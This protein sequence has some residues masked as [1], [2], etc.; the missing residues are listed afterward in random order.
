M[1]EREVLE[2]YFKQ[3]ILLALVCT[4]TL[5]SG[6]NFPARRVIVRTPM[7]IGGKTIDIMSYRQMIGRAGRKGIDTEGESILMCSNAAE[8]RLGECLINSELPELSSTMGIAAPFTTKGNKQQNVNELASSMKRAILE[9]IV[10]GIATTKEDLKLYS[11]CFLSKQE[12]EIKGLDIDIYLNWLYKNEFIDVVVDKTS[13]ET[14]PQKQS[15]KPTQLGFA[16][17]SSAMCPDEGIL[18]F[19]ELQKA[20]QCFVLENELHII[21][22]ITPINICD[23]WSSSSSID[24]NVYYSMIQNMSNDYKR[25]ADLVGVRQS[26]ILKMIKNGSNTMTTINDKKLSRIHLR[27]YTALILN[28]LVNEVNFNTILN[29]YGCQK[30]FLQSLQQSSSTYASMVTVFCNRLGWLN[31]ELLLDQF[32]SRLAFGVQRQ[33]LDLIRLDLLNSN[34]A[35]LFYNAGFTTVASIAMVNDLKKIEKILRSSLVFSTITNNNDKQFNDAVIWHEGRSYTYWDASICIFDQANQILKKD[36]D[37]LGIK[38]ELK[39]KMNPNLDKTGNNSDRTNLFQMIDDSAFNTTTSQRTSQNRSVIIKPIAEIEDNNEIMIISPSPKKVTTSQTKNSQQIESTQADI[40]LN[41]FLLKNM[42]IIEQNSAKKNK[43]KTQS[44]TSSYADNEA[45]LQMN[46]TKDFL[47]LDTDKKSRKNLHF[48]KYYQTLNNQQEKEE[49]DDELIQAVLIEENHHSR[50]KNGKNNTLKMNETV[51]SDDILKMCDIFENKINSNLSSPS[52]QLRHRKIQESNKEN[53]NDKQLL[54]DTNY[55]DQLVKMA[56]GQ[57]LQLNII[58]TKENYEEFYSNIKLKSLISLSLCTEIIVKPNENQ[59]DFYQFYDSQRNVHFRLLGLFIFIDDEKTN[60]INFFLFKKEMIF[61]EYLK[62]LLEKDDFIKI[63]FFTKDV[64]TMLTKAFNIHLKVPSYDPIVAN[65]L[66]NQEL[67][68][69]YQMKQKYSPNVNINLDPGLRAFKGSYAIGDTK[70]ITSFS[71]LQRSFFECIIGFNC[72]QKLKL[73]LEMQNLWIYFHKIE[74][75][76]VIQSAQL[77]LVGFALDLN[78]LKQEQKKLLKKKKEIEDTIGAIVGREVHL[79]SPNDVA[80]VLYDHLKLKLKFD[81]ENAK[82]YYSHSDRLK[83]RSTGKDILQQLSYQHDLPKLIILWRKINHTLTQCIYP[84]D[85][86]M[87]SFILL[88]L[89]LLLLLSLLLLKHF[90]KLK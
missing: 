46:I 53:K 29:K 19:T 23:Y 80:F 38:I 60:I 87:F 63:I 2:G 67:L 28:D 4:T 85:K 72:F 9:T 65:W 18:I 66:L 57:K 48:S 8:K 39:S 42:K 62:R 56:N 20:Q 40:E 54:K 24:W 76:I 21:Y 7:G 3:G 68:T 5:S 35:R 33:L 78:H 79:S 15:Y 73:Q 58:E 22:Q 31:L 25:V 26:F 41:N 83:H 1:E 82:K 51:V 77:E 44:P 59:L 89:L 13:T 47:P 64:Y 45:I 32:Q 52:V 17:V 75:E 36:M 70:L 16:V 88:S 43:K 12:I 84:L 55:F 6:I 81:D 10:S 86:V 74:S 90:L 11:N 69:I 30:G 27:F 14:N 34:R 37:T 49:K 50:S 71:P 61:K